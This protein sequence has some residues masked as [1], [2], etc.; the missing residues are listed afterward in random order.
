MP[1]IWI[2]DKMYAVDDAEVRDYV[3]KL[4]SRVADMCEILA[5]YIDS[6]VEYAEQDHYWECADC[7]KKCAERESIEHD[8]GCLVV[9]AQAALAAKEH[10]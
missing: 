10:N 1:K 2:G 8:T 4:R 7:G 5:D 3:E 6:N 9:R